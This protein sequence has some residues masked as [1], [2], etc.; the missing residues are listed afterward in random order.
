[1]ETTNSAVMAPITTGLIGI[2]T[3]LSV[4][5]IFPLQVKPVESD[6][7]QFSPIQN[8]APQS[9]RDAKSKNGLTRPMDQETIK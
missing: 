5:P 9:I 2:D 4:S 7:L 1:L 8:M 6:T 3:M